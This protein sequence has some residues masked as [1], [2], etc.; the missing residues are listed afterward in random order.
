MKYQLNLF[1]LA[2]GFFS[3]I[4]IPRWVEYSPEKLNQASRYFAIVGWL[5]GGLVAI[6]FYLACQLFSQQIA[7][8]LCILLSLALTGVF[9]EDGLADTADGFGGGMSKDK[10]LSIMKDSRLGTYGV[11]ALIIAL[12]GK[13][14]FLSELALPVAAILLA[15]P[16]SRAIAGSFIFD[17]TYLTETDSKSKPLAMQQTVTEL[18]VLLMSGAIGLLF[19][20]MIQA[21]LLLVTLV[22]LRFALKRWLL[23][24]IGGYTGDNLGAVQQISELAI[25]MILHIIWLQS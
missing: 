12:L 23:S 16:L 22:V 25:Y 5:L 24:Q 2:L 8:F 6:A 20:E 17:M 13:W 10:K 11:T 1:F 19:L 21:L 14:L 15:Y 18:L 4:P 3:R 7:A 9:H